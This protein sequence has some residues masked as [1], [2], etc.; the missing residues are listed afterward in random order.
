[1]AE[2][3]HPQPSEHVLSNDGREILGHKP[4][5]L[6]CRGGTQVQDRDEEQALGPAQRQL[7]IHDLLHQERRNQLQHRSQE[8]R[9]AHQGEQPAPGLENGPQLAQGNT[10]LLL[11]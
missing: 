10:A 5:H 7:L 6:H 4:H 9:D 8:H 3:A 11:G 1:M 2:E